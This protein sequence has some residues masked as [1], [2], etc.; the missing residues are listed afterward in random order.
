[1]TAVE[2]QSSKNYSISA[3]AFA[4]AFHSGAVHVG[5]TAPV[6]GHLLPDISKQKLCLKLSVTIDVWTRSHIIENSV[7]K[8]VVF[9]KSLILFHFFFYVDFL[10]KDLTTEI[11]ENRRPV[12]T[13][14]KLKRTCKKKRLY[15]IFYFSRLNGIKK[16]SVENFENGPSKQR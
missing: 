5:H 11:R 12:W 13:V 9:R 10:A 6:I 3:F 7:P 15:L 14:N 16:N 8:Y 2:T 4:F 1:M